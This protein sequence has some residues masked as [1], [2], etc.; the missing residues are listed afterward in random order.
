MTANLSQV[1]LDAIIDGLT[2]RILNRADIANV[3]RGPQG[4]QGPQGTPA[5]QGNGGVQIIDTRWRIEEFGLFEPDLPVDDRNPPGDVITVGK[6]SIYRNV[7]AFCERVKDAI[8]TKGANTVRDNLQLCL[9]G[10]ASRWWTFEL[11]DIDKLAIRGDNSPGLLQWVTRLQSRFRPRMAQAAR[12]NSEL[13]FKI[14]DVRAGKRVLSYFQSK[15]LKACAAGFESLQAQLIQVYSSMDVALRRDLFEPT[16]QTTL[17]Q[18]REALMEKEEL[19]IE[20]YKPRF[21]I[22]P[23]RT[24]QNRLYPNAYPTNRP[25]N[26]QQTVN[27]RP[28]YGANQYPTN[29]YVT[30]QYGNVS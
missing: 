28:T 2:N 1:D 15:I 24:P 29:Q 11:S 21:Q 22:S 4:P 12:E 7:D 30:N 25:Q 23:Q 27:Q 6:D 3:L 14:S 16:P 13:T 19:W 5:A 17:D 10:A 20:A 9:R 18:Y 26:P 8:A